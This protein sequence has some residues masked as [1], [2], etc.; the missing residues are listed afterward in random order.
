MIPV[1]LI[2]STVYL[3][4]QLIRTNLSHEKYLEEARTRV[5]E[6][7]ERLDELQRENV[8]LHDDGRIVSTSKPGKWW[9]F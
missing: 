1:A 6:L 7:E 4:L 9:F 2:G 5:R 8:H 3:A